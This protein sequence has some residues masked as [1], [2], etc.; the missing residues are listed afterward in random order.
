MKQEEVH[1]P[2]STVVLVFGALSIPLAFAAHLCS[3]AVVLSLYAI[4]FGLWGQRRAR[5]HLLRYSTKSTARARLGTRL[6]LVGG[7]CGTLMWVLWAS[8]VLLD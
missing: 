3:L 6:G 5:R 2:F 7:A 4:G 8:N 1:L